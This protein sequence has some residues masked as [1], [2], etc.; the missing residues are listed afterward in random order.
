MLLLFYAQLNF[1]E[2]IVKLAVHTEEVGQNMSLSCEIVRRHNEYRH[3]A[4]ATMT[5]SGQ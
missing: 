1:E 2:Q 5:E 4:T 3:G